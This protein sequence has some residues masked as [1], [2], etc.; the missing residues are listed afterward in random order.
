MHTFIM[1]TIFRECDRYNLSHSLKW[2]FE[3]WTM[4]EW[5]I[6]SYYLLWTPSSVNATDTI[7]RTHWNGS[8]RGEPCRSDISHHI[9][10]Y[11]SVDPYRITKSMDM[12]TVTFLGLKIETNTKCTTITW[13]STVFL[14]CSTIQII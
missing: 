2:F 12:E 13:F 10:Y 6:T 9:I 11:P 1:N 4:S 8:L 5:H 14:S 7:C 3:G